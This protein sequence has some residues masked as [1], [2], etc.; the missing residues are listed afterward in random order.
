MWKQCA[1]SACATPLIDDETMSVIFVLLDG[2]CISFDQ[3]TGEIRWKY[4]LTSP[5]FSSPTLINNN[6]IL[7]ISDVNGNIV[8]LRK[9]SGEKLWNFNISEHVF[10]DLVT[11]N[12]KHVRK[13]INDGF[14]IATKSGNVY[15]YD[16]INDYI[17]RKLTYKINC[18]SS[19]F[20]SPWID[21]RFILIAQENGELQFFNLNNGTSLS[22]FKLHGEC[23]SSPVFHQN[24]I[25]VGSRDNNLCILKI[26]SKSCQR[27]T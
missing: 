24:L 10:S 14:I 7:I 8:A 16:F 6:K 25:F 23:F 2:N 21:E 4:Q 26:D 9:H 27:D 3:I 13:E 19:I 11:I 20:A 5:I 22:T 15:R 17:D 12:N 1:A 18:E